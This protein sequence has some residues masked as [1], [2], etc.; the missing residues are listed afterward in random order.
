M[1]NCS[2][3]FGFGSKGGAL[4][5]SMIGISKVSLIKSNFN[6]CG[7]SISNSISEGGGIYVS[8]L[9]TDSLDFYIEEWFYAMFL[10]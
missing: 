1:D 7:C 6:N 10:T 4:F 8:L 5:L 3:L 2:F 9:K